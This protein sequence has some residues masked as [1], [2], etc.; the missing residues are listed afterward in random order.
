MT[1]PLLDIRSL[2]VSYGRVEAVH[3]VTLSVEPGSIVT[4]SPWGSPWCRSGG[5]CSGP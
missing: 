1:T 5:S 2:V 4:A 3:G